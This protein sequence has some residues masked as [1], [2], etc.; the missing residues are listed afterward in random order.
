M[1]STMKLTVQGGMSTSSDYRTPAR[2]HLRI[3][4]RTSSVLLADVTL[5]AEEWLRLTNGTM[6]TVDGDVSPHLE[7]V[8]RKMV[9]RRLGIPRNAVPSYNREQAAV[10]ARDWAEPRA[11][12]GETTEVRDTNSGWIAIYRSWPEA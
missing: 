9:V 10:E 1:M 4:D 6:L 7:R 5:T 2:F 3:E 8:G 12:E 11:E